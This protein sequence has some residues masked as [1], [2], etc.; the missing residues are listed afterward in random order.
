MA[1]LAQSYHLTSELGRFLY[2]EVG[3]EENGTPL[4]I[5]SALA[6]LGLDP[7]REAARLAQLP[8]DEAAQ[9]LAFLIARLP[10][11]VELPERQAIVNRL[12]E[13][14]PKPALGASGRTQ[15]DWTTLMMWAV[16]GSIL[17]MKPLLAIAIL[18][19]WLDVSASPA[20]V[21]VS[22][23]P[24]PSRQIQLIVSTSQAGANDGIARLISERLAGV[25]EQPVSAASHSKVVAGPLVAQAEPDGHT[26]LIAQAAEVAIDPVEFRTA[27]FD[28]RRD[29][30]PIALV[31]VAP[32]AITVPAVSPW[33]TM[34][35][36]MAASCSSSLG[37]SFVS[38]EPGTPEAF[39]SQMLRSRIQTR[40]ARE[41]DDGRG[42]CVDA[43]LRCK[44]N[45]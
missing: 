6:R 35:D 18:S 12:A 1:A 20:P 9:E 37:L 22:P 11:P 2:F 19:G 36:L 10:R 38:A 30:Q 23:E 29:L 27:D 13:L 43:P 24:F 26:L 15:S 31:G 42:T 3:Q 32:L 21:R 40:L 33:T 44:K 17:L 25:L 8:K 39:A 16:L 7:W 41:P 28:P 4:T 45:L 14:L 34:S 5:L